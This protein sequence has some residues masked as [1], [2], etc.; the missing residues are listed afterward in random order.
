MGRRRRPP[1]NPPADPIDERARLH[2]SCS[3]SLPD[4]DGPG[5]GRRGVAR[6]ITRGELPVLSTASFPTV[7]V[8]EQPP[9]DRRRVLFAAYAVLFVRCGIATRTLT[10]ALTC[11]LTLTLTLT[12]NPRYNIATFLS[13]FFGSSATLCTDAGECIS[14]TWQVPLPH[15]SPACSPSSL[16][17]N[18]NPHPTPNPNQGLI[19]AA[20]PLG[21]AI[22]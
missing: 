20:Y 18:P 3:S 6:L 7:A 21:M 14:G 13:A 12:P 5:P 2:L 8:P 10:L 11:T 4:V 19:F 17:P 16:R 15:S 1:S 22:T 9:P